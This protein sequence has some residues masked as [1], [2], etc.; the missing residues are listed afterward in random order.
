MYFF[1][2]LKK[3]LITIVVLFLFSCGG[4]SFTE[5]EQKAVDNCAEEN[6]RGD[7]EC[8]V[9]K[10]VKSLSPEEYSVMFNEDD[11]QSQGLEGLNFA[12]SAMTKMLTA[13]GSC[14]VEIKF[15]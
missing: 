5:A 11:S 10:T 6:N 4:P 2:N 14:G 13:A 12:M 7:C 8:M 1:F 3:F 15:E 9:N